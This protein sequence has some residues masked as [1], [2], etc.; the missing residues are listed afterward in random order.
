MPTRL[1]HYYY[2]RLQRLMRRLARSAGTEHEIALGLGIGM[3]IGLLPLVGIQMVVAA[4][5]ATVARANRLAAIL[6]VWLTNPLTLVPIYSFNYWVGRKLVGGPRLRDFL[7]QFH[8]VIAPDKGVV[9][10][11]KTLADMG[12]DTL[13][14]LWL[15]CAVVGVAAAV[16]TYFL[17]RQLVCDF[18]RGLAKRRAARHQRLH[19]AR[20][21]QAHPQTDT[22]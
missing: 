6:P 12:V 2:L 11:L 9:D 13:L 1:P 7:H 16:P 3:F 22:P 4:V 10:A 15:G 20:Q 18:R 14:P 17:G 5:C 21:A 19:E 8:E